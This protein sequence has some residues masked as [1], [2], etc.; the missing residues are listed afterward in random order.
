M[1]ENNSVPE[2]KLL[3]KELNQFKSSV[4]FRINNF[5]Y[6]ED[7]IESKEFK[8]GTNT[9][10]LIKFKPNEMKDN[11]KYI[12]V[13]LFLVESDSSSVSA[14]YSVSIRNK[15]SAKYK[16]WSIDEFD[17]LVGG[18]GRGF[19]YL[20]SR[21]I[22]MQNKNELIPNNILTLLFDIELINYSPNSGIVD[23]FKRIFGN[24]NLSDFKFVV[25]TETFYVHKIIL[26]TR[27][28]VFEV[29][30]GTEM[31]EKQQNEC[32]IE[33][34]DCEVF[35]ELLQFIYTG[36]TR[37]VNSIAHKLLIASEK[38]NI[39]RLKEI[40]EES[41]ASQITNENS[42]ENLLFADKY[43]AI[44]LHHKVID[45]I[46]DNL[47][48]IRVSETTGWKDFISKYPDLVDSIFEAIAEKFEIMKTKQNEVNLTFN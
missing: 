14:K 40:C 33:D 25:G 34:I 12:S 45:Y 13:F 17:Y 44:Q 31:K 7:N 11:M 15:K 2:L 8:I 10:W 43:N 27:S 35:G 22:L 6:L 39:T 26:S 4:I 29:M 20:A 16:T 32:I 36:K 24:R 37:K 23:D 38:Y 28:T 41:I 47:D 48:P 46:I 30:F 18:G 19:P 1:V 9:K 21:Q 5:S 42:I 3:L